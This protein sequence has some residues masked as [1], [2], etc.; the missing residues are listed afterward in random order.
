MASRKPDTKAATET[1]VEIEGVFDRMARWATGNPTRFLGGLGAVLALAA[2]IGGAQALLERQ[3]LQ[4]SEALAEAK[5]AYFEGMG[6]NPGATTIV[7]PANP[8]TAREVRTTSIERFLAVAE[9]H[10]GSRAA[11]EALLEA[12]EI[13]KA[14]GE[15][16]AALETWRRAV[17]EAPD[18]TVLAG[19]ALSQLA[20]ALESRGEWAEAAGLHEQAAGI[21]AYPVRYLAMVEAAYAYAMADEPT[22]AAALY[23]RVQTEAQD[24]EIAEHVRARL[25]RA[26]A[27]AGSD[28]ADS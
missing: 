27:T 19:L 15:P 8:E 24:L 6:A 9:E 10:A 7:E 18:R 26:S 28:A 5:Y 14:L 11:V 17:D 20:R 4:A 3:E 1:L 16:D 23:A 25:D 2:G 22:Q 13:Q 12:G 21:I